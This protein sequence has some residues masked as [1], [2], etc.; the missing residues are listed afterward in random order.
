MGDYKA[1][2]RYVSPHRLGSGTARSAPPAVFG[3]FWSASLADV[4]L[5]VDDFLTIAES[6]LGRRP[7]VD[8]SD[9]RSIL[10]KRVITVPDTVSGKHREHS[11]AYFNSVCAEYE[12]GWFGYAGSALGQ[13]CALRVN[14]ESGSASVVALN[15]WLPIARDELMDQFCGNRSHPNAGLAGGN[16]GFSAKELTG[17]YDGGGNIFRKAE[18]KALSEKQI[19]CI[20]GPEGTSPMVVSFA[21]DEKHNLVPDPNHLAPGIGFFAEPGTGVPCLMVGVAS[22]KRVAG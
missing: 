2:E 19:Q 5:T 11:P 17:H 22:L 7:E 16:V 18:V 8:F 13:T 6:L 20:V 4:T 10:K 21:L 9:V 3:P 12:G 15:A 1:R 14:F